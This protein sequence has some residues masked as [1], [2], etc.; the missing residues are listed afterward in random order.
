MTA[1]E[2][3]VW[4][5]LWC[6]FARPGKMAR[7][8]ADGA[9]QK[10]TSP[11]RMFLATSLLLFGYIAL[12]GTQLVALGDIVDRTDAP[13]GVNAAIH[14]ESDGQAL[15]QRLR[16]FVR[17]KNLILPNSATNDALRKQFLDGLQDADLDLLDEG[18]LQDAIEELDDQIAEADTPAERTALQTIRNQLAA[19]APTETSSDDEPTGTEEEPNESYLNL[20]ALG[21][22]EGIQLRGSEITELYNRVVSNPQVINNQLNS[23]LKWA[24]FFMMPLAM[25]L[26]AIFIRG[27]D[28]AMLYDHLVHAAYVHAFSFILLFVFILLSQYTS[29][30]GL[31]PIYTLILLI[32]LPLSARGA[33]QRGRFK[34]VLTAYG[35]GSIY[36]L[37]M[38]FIALGIVIFALGDVAR[39]ISDNRAEPLPAEVTE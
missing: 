19:R 27:R 30:S 22:G 39:D 1:L 3:R 15:E 23:K 32:Y 5:S 36:T 25:F 18:D 33:F 12:S 17:E 13:P 37:A 4:R 28:T 9:R 7:E 26:G 35:V 38:F 10:W 2:G 16:F 21:G 31:L 24:M 29:L 8:Y 14:S 11:I 6:L 20:G 34:S